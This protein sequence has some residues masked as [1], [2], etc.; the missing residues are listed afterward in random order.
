MKESEIAK[1]IGERLQQA[2]K[3]ADMD[4]AELARLTGYPQREIENWELGRAVMYPSEMVILCHTLDKT[5][6]WLL[7]WGNH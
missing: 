1:G 5:P 2:M 4:R 6:H 7:G 3:E